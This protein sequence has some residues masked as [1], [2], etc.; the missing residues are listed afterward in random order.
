MHIPGRLAPETWRIIAEADLERKDV[1]S[2]SRASKLLRN[3]IQ[4]FLYRNVNLTKMSRDS[5]HLTLGLIASEPTLAS[6]VLE[7]TL[8][9]YPPY[10]DDIA[11][12]GAPPP[13]DPSL[14]TKAFRSMISLRSFTIAELDP[15]WSRG[16]NT[17]GDL[18]RAVLGRDDFVAMIQER[19]TPLKHF[20]WKRVDP[21]KFITRAHWEV[22]FEAQSGEWYLVYQINDFRY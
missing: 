9:S 8:P 12:G 17:G 7:L 1:N 11:R 13:P 4:P 19:E 10:D 18:A 3:I 15:F 6:S 14:L 21:D 5:Q 22:S 20:T 16:D 2:L